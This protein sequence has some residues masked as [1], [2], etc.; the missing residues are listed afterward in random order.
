M[1]NIMN[2]SI[3]GFF[4][5]LI[6]F[7]FGVGVHLVWNYTSPQEIDVGAVNSSSFTN[8]VKITA[9]DLIDQPD[10]FDDKMVEFE[11]VSYIPYKDG[12]IILNAKD[13]FCQSRDP[14]LPARLN[15][16]AVDVPDRHLVS[17]IEG[18]KRRSVGDDKE[19]DISVI[20]RAKIMFVEGKHRT[21]SVTPTEVR[22]LSPFREF[23]PKGA[24]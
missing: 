23:V 16:N 6:A 3:I 19:V 1:C 12:T 21:Y 9:C 17:V 7:L 18:L 8:V 24:G 20:G 5:G 10:M 15:F 22:I 2:R 4:I 11:A 13:C 14:L